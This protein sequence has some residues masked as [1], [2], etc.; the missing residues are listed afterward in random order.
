MEAHLPDHI[1]PQTFFLDQIK[2]ERQT[3]NP[4]KPFSIKPEKK[5]WIDIS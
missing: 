5:F 4:Q 2:V 3:T 1:K